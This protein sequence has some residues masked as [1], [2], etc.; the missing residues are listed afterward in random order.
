MPKQRKTKWLVGLGL[1]EPSVGPRWYCPHFLWMFAGQP[2]SRVEAGVRISHLPGPED[3]F[4]FCALQ[5]V[6]PRLEKAILKIKLPSL[7]ICKREMKNVNY[8][9]LPWGGKLSQKT[10]N[11]QTKLP[12]FVK[13]FFPQ[14]FYSLFLIKLLRKPKLISKEQLRGWSIWKAPHSPARLPGKS[15]SLWC[16]RE[17]PVFRDCNKLSPWAKTTHIKKTND[18]VITKVNELNSSFC[19]QKNVI[20]LHIPVD[21]SMVVQM[22]KALHG[23]PAPQQEGGGRERDQ[24]CQQANSTVSSK[25]TLGYTIP[26]LNSLC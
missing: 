3:R 14:Y 2:A 10:K 26:R 15:P 9:Q 6:C 24:N 17:A 1:S 12:F 20:P 5:I 22:L 21:D 18:T 19:C 8:R 23:V 7:F 25:S 11:K 4:T 16:S 13:F